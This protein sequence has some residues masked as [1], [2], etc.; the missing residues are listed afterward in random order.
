[1][2][3]EQGRG[4]SWPELE[5]DPPFISDRPEGPPS[6]L[7]RSLPRGIV[8]L[9]PT[10]PAVGRVLIVDDDALTRRALDRSLSKLGHR[11]TQIASGEEALALLEREPY[12]L[13]LLDVVMPG[14][15]GYEVLERIKQHPRLHEI[16]VV[17]ISGLDDMDSVAR[18]VELGAE[19]YLI[20]PAH[21]TLLRA[22]V[23][24][25]LAR[26]LA[27]DRENRYRDRIEDEGRRADRLLSAIFPLQ[28]I[29]E[30]KE[31]RTV[32]P[33]VHDDVAVLFCDV[34]G[35]TAYCGTHAPEQV[36]AGLQRMVES[37]EAISA[38]HG[39]EKIKTIGDAFL[40]TAGLL[41]D[42]GRPVARCV[43]AAREIVRAVPA[44][45]SGWQVRVGIHVGSVMAGV[46]G[47]QQYGFD[48]W[49]DTVNTASR[50]QALGEPGVVTLSA[51]ARQRVTDHCETA[52]LGY[53]AIKGKGELE[54][55]RV[56]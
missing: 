48:V 23:D 55:F 36:V 22:R 12:D 1:M 3:D 46:V 26:K 17:M 15:N 24:A 49:G 10:G 5:V 35:F 41:G 51:E 32:K 37:L 28:V 6:G 16:P 56:C 21:S 4:G 8:A 11:V 2:A 54:L 45:P 42:S 30:L 14:L 18:C 9:T 27:R 52:S 39:L 13:V 29:E 50:V 40:A 25:S 31:T 33:R 47:H 43:D 7:L 53:H 20:K 19:D 38:R 44:Q 34:A